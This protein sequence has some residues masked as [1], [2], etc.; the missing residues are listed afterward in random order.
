[1]L[2]QSFWNRR[3]KL[4]C[5]TT[6]TK[7]PASRGQVTKEEQIPSRTAA[8]SPCGL[9]QAKV[10]VDLWPNL[11]KQVQRFWKFPAYSYF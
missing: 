8:H 11:A 3:V 10:W 1:M 2:L 5:A 6:K 9:R 7:G 4:L